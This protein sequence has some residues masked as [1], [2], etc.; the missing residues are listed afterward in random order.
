MQEVSFAALVEVSERAM[1]HCGKKELLLGGGVASSL[2]LQ[3][4]CSIMCKER[5]AKSYSLPVEVN[6]DNGLMIAWLGILM[7]KAGG[8]TLPENAN[9]EPYLRT[10]DIDVYW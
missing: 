9:I 5:D 10:D 3:E 7:H 1:A 4:M 8:I 2:R 6:V